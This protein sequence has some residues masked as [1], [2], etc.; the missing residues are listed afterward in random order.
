MAEIL[1]IGVIEKT[2]N[3]EVVD[4]AFCSSCPLYSEEMIGKTT[5]YCDDVK[6]GVSEHYRCE[7]VANCRVLLGHLK[8]NP[9]AMAMLVTEVNS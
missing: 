3:V 2:I 9:K 1:K 8:D 7:H 5:I 4:P 6:Y